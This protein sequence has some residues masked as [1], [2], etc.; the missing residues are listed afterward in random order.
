MLAN[1][2][3]QL[4]DFNV[5]G[6]NGVGFEPRAIVK[7]SDQPR[8]IGA[9][10]PQQVEANRQAHERGDGADQCAEK[11]HVLLA[12]FL[13]NI[14]PILPDNDVCQHSQ[15]KDEGGEGKDEGGKWRR[16]KL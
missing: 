8:I 12:N 16:H 3:A 15:F 9:R 5:C 10:Q 7:D 4:G 6:M 11:T 14:R 2:S 13:F 1:A